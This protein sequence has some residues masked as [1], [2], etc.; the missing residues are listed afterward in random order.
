ML[1]AMWPSNGAGNRI[2]MD[3]AVW[4]SFLFIVCKIHGTDY[5]TNAHCLYDTNAH[6]NT[7]AAHASRDT[8]P[9]TV[10]ACW[11]TGDVNLVMCR[12]HALTPV[13]TLMSRG[14]DL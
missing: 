10:A 1:T 5:D 13:L 2:T 11:R 7:R 12:V 4:Y 8:I 6:Q 9:C 3:Y 14:V